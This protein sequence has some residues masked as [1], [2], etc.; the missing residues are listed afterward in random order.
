MNSLYIA[1]LSRTNL[2]PLPMGVIVG[3]GRGLVVVLA[4]V[5]MSLAM[6]IRLFVVS[7]ETPLC[8][9]QNNY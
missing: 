8:P 9:N 3:A 6:A 1:S 7:G 5:C 2:S 4:S